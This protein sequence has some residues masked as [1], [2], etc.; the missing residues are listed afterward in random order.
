M[1]GTGQG[2][3]PGLPGKGL[4]VRDD[5]YPNGSCP[6]NN[7]V[8]LSPFLALFASFADNHR[9]TDQQTLDQLQ[10]QIGQRLEIGD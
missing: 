2:P 8:F 3:G 6:Q 9:S 5:K 1:T 4:G 7:P 10:V